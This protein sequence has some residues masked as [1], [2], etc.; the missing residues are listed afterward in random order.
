MTNPHYPENVLTHIYPLMPLF[1]L[2]MAIEHP[3]STSIH[4]YA[5]FLKIRHNHIFYRVPIHHYFIN[6]PKCIIEISWSI[7]IEAYESSAVNTPTFV[8]SQYLYASSCTICLFPLS[9]FYFL[10]LLLFRC[11]SKSDIS[12]FSFLYLLSSLRR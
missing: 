2:I 10:L 5:Y 11:F 7:S 1:I 8:I 12:I 4:T 6:I 3:S 9:P